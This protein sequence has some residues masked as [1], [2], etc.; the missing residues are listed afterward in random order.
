[1]KKLL[2]ILIGLVI[3]AGI[4]AQELTI[5]SLEGEELGE[6][7]IVY[8]EGDVVNEIVFHA[9]VT[10]NTGS[11]MTVMCVRSQI[12]MLPGTSSQFCWGENCYPPFVDTAGTA[13]V[14]PGGATTA[15]DAFSG[16]Y[17]PGGVHGTS[18]V[19]YKFYNI[20]DPSQ[21]DEVIC[22]YV[23]GFVGVDD[24]FEAPS[25]SEFYPNPATDNIRLDY[26]LGSSQ[27]ATLKVVNLLGAV[28]KEIALDNS[29][30]LSM[31]VSDLKQGVYFCSVV[32][33]GQVHTTKRIV[34]Q[35]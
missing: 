11:D 4:Y 25:F 5:K 29:N 6:S 10:N 18:S 17:A 9:L 13:L 3:S 21:Y 32:A 33:E 24:N 2:L 19:K 34:V 23:Y 1:M 22:H 31:D 28:V 30:S 35:K 8:D 14:I 7:I 12:D 16:H 26:N 15:D 20:D 27:Q